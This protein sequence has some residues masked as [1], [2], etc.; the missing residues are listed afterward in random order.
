MKLLFLHLIETNSIRTKRYLLSPALHIIYL[1]IFCSSLIFSQAEKHSYAPINP[2][3]IKYL[4]QKNSG[5]LQTYTSNGYGLGYIPDVINPYFGDAYLKKISGRSA[6]FPMTYDLRTLGY[7]TSVKDQV[8]SGPCWAFASIG[9]MESNWLINAYG[10]FD[11][12]ERNM[13]TC[14]GFDNTICQGGN[15]S[16]AS[17]YLTRRD[18]PISE[19]DDPY[20]GINCSASCNTGFIPVAYVS[21]SRFL[22]GDST[23][24]KQAIIDFGAVAS[25]MYYDNSYFNSSDNTYYYNGSSFTNHGVLVVGWDDT[26]VT[27]GGTGAWI[28]KNSWG[29]SFGENGYFY[30]SYNDSRLLSSNIVYPVRN[31]YEANGYVYYYDK[32]GRTTN[33]GYGTNTAYGLVKFTA[34][35]NHELT[36][37]GT[38]ASAANAVLDIE[39]YDD[40]NGTALSNLLGTIPQQSC[41]YPGFYTFDLSNPIIIGSG[42]DFYVKIEYYTP[43]YTF[44]IPMENA[45]PGYITNPVI[46]TG[47]CWI[48]PDESTWIPI[49]TGTST[50]ADI[51]IKAYGVNTNQSVANFSAG[52]TTIGVADS[53]DFTDLSTG[54][55]TSWTWNF[56]GAT[57]SSSYVQNPVNI[58]YNNAGDYDVSLTVSN[59]Y[60]SHTLTKYNYIKVLQNWGCDTITN[61]VTGDQSV[62]YTLG[63]TWGYIAGHNGYAMNKYADKFT[64]TS[65]YLLGGIFAK[66][67]RAHSGSPSSKIYFKIWDENVSG[68]PGT[69]IYSKLVYIDSLNA[70][71]INY[72]YIEFDSLVYVNNDYFAG[73]MLLYPNPQDTIVNNVALNRSSNPFNTAYTF[74]NGSWNSF[75]NLFGPSLGYTSL[76]IK[77]MRCPFNSIPVAHFSSNNTTISQGGYVYFYDQ[78][79]GYPNSF[80]WF[81]EG[82]NPSSSTNKNPVVQYTSP[83][84]YGVSLIASNQNGSDSVFKYNYITV[85]PPGI[86]NI[87]GTFSYDNEQLPQTPIT[88]EKIYLKNLANNIL[89][90]ASTDSKGY[91]YFSSVPN[92][93]YIVE[94][95]C[96]KTWAGV[97][98]DDALMIMKHFVQIE[99]LEAL[100]LLAADVSG[101]GWINSMDAMNVQQRFLGV[102]NSFAAG[103]WILIS[104]TITIANN[105]IGVYFKTLCFGDVNR[106]HIPAGGN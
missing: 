36:K 70:S 66:I 49:G 26:K 72:N 90:S 100:A 4:E 7:V 9:S 89:D 98:T 15:N 16:M 94:P 23:T 45:Q 76:D 41:T 101:E 14:H 47:K 91:F 55:P 12:S 35:V 3:Y 43:S 60:G 75:T 85:R 31:N 68:N 67:S 20:P 73:F 71:G 83:G 44:P 6:K 54:N 48:S 65:D 25:N 105:S 32:F 79:N 22:P 59:A 62:F 40:F 38:Y 82:G 53:V 104:D 64:N 30:V 95:S 42:N 56:P 69:E 88:G 77:I 102:I 27:A 63:G 52:S 46:E 57:P 93:T 11:L 29:T 84:I 103:N 24:I 61:F 2:D 17:A 21:D 80:S 50:L 106:S 86:N 33:T 13:A 19:N 37:I 28:I 58:V 78:S 18:G 51:C 81:F 1:L 10:T 87:Y 97:S 92:G 74:Y 39:I 99:N 96:N 34:P 5:T 8:V